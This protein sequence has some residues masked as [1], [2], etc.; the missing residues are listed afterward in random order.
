M[1]L[2]FLGVLIVLTPLT[3]VSPSQIAV[4]SSPVMNVP[5]SPDL[6]GFHWIVIGMFVNA[7]RLNV[8]MN[9]SF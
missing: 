2:I 4:T 1:A 9:C 5:M 8:S 6:P 7:C 3:A